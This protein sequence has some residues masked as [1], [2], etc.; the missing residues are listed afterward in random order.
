MVVSVSSCAFVDRPW[1]CGHTE[2]STKSHERN[3]KLVIT[4][5]DFE[6]KLLD[7]TTFSTFQQIRLDA[8]HVV[9]RVRPRL[10][11]EREPRKAKFIKFSYSL[12]RAHQMLENWKGFSATFGRHP[13][14]IGHTYNTD[15]VANLYALAI[16]IIRR[17]PVHKCSAASG[18]VMK[19]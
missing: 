18:C 9:P 1:F 4:E 12:I 8:N 6:A 15:A 13:A 19:P 7:A 16:D 5:I 2:R 11:S 3:T 17:Q 10:N 14:Q